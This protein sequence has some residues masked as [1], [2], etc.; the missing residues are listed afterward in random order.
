MQAKDECKINEG[1][2]TERGVRKMGFGNI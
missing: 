2:Q 1:K